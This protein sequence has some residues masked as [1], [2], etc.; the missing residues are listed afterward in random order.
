MDDILPD[1][2]APLTNAQAT[3]YLKERW[4]LDLSPRTLATFRRCGRGPVCCDP[5]RL[6]YRRHDLDNW[7]A[8]RFGHRESSAETYTPDLSRSA[9][10][11][12]D[13]EF[14]VT[15]DVAHPVRWLIAGKPSPDRDAEYDQLVAYG[16]EVAGPFDDA[17]AA[18]SAAATQRIDAALL[19]MDWNVE[20]GIAVTDL[21][22]DRRVPFVVFTQ[23]REV[24]ATILHGGTVIPVPHD[25]TFPDFI[26]TRFPERL[27]KLMDLS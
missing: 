14:D 11:A 15:T 9:V 24:P 27:T 6:L 17:R 22:V 5:I 1:H 16:C 25:L 26:E 3:K 21:L 18:I 12:T 13:R 19:D 7:A 10:S 4:K 23:L 20:G 8:Y 2:A